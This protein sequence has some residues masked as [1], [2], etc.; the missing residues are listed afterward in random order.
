MA[1]KI[2]RRT[3]RMCFLCVTYKRCFVVLAR[4]G[5]FGIL[6]VFFVYIPK[7]KPPTQATIPFEFLSPFATFF[8]YRPPFNCVFLFSLRP[9]LAC[10][11]PPLFPFYSSSLSHLHKIVTTVS[12]NLSLALI[13]T[14]LPLFRRRRP[15]VAFFAH[16]AYT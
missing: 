11:L 13:Y 1:K 8:F 15:R 2:K 12:P 14:P 10:L 4:G 3:R 5:C 7:A 6:A 16:V 9:W